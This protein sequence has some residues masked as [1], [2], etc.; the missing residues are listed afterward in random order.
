MNIYVEE[1][2]KTKKKL[3]AGDERVIN[4]VAKHKHKFNN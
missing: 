2:T 3:R 4:L 1:P